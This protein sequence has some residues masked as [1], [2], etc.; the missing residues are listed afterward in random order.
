MFL[1][2]FLKKDRVKAKVKKQKDFYK[3]TKTK[4]IKRVKLILY[5]IN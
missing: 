5:K 3:E 2:P 4:T 1:K